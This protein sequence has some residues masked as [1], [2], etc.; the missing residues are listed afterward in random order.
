MLFLECQDCERR[1]A[2]QVQYEVGPGIMLQSTRLG[3]DECAEDQQGS[4]DLD[5]LFE[6]DNAPFSERRLVVPG[7]AC[8]VRA[9][10]LSNALPFSHGAAALV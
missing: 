3:G 9:H 7:T 10:P 2:N 8:L 1:G 5:D 6:H 4:S